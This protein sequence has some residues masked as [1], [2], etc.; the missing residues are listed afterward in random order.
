[1][2][3]ILLNE[4]G[5]KWAYFLI[6]DSP[7]EHN[8]KGKG[9]Y[10]QKCEVFVTGRKNHNAISKIFLFHLTGLEHQ[11]LKIMHDSVNICLSDL[12]VIRQTTGIMK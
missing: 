9:I 2:C 1:M 7:S 8:L 11:F 12:T 6:Y 5:C 4:V 3:Y 10:T